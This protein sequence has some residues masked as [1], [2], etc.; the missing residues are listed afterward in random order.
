MKKAILPLAIVFLVVLTQAQF[1]SPQSDIPAYSKTPPAKGQVL[2]KILTAQELA[3]NGVDHPA[4]LAAY[5][6][7]ARVPA[8]MTQQPCY[9]FCDRHHGHTN[10][11]SCFEDMHGAT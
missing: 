5:K 7:A 1:M 11:H 3:A 10:L 9:C 6:A 8:A 2:P 4:A